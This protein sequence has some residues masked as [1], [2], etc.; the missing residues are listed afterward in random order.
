[1][2][3]VEDEEVK[4][5]EQVGLGHHGEEDHVN[6]RGLSHPILSFIEQR[7]AKDWKMV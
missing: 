3:R 1:M 6:P 4:K 2:R 7:G 5:G